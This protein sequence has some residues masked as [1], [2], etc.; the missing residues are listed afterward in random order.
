MAK[1]I[2]YYLDEAKRRAAVT[3]PL[4]EVLPDEPRAKGLPSFRVYV[5]EQAWFIPLP[6]PYSYAF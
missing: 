4:S 1:D 3:E 2:E 5:S 6:T